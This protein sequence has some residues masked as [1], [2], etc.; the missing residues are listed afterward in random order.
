MPVYNYTTLDDP[1]HGYA[2]VSAST[3]RV[4]S[5]GVTDTPRQVHGFLL[6]GG[7]Y[8][9]L[10]DPLATNTKPGTEHQQPG[11]DRRGLRRRQRRPR[12]P[13]QR[14]PLTP[15]STIPRASRARRAGHQRRRSDRRNL[16]GQQRS[17]SRLPLERQH[18]HHHRRS[19]G[20]GSTIAARASTTMGQIVGLLRQSPAATTRF[21]LQRRHLHHHR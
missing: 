11:P 19:L 14:W 12:L 16:P 9:T 1:W 18:L 13:S 6:S 21:P 8:T 7:T 4:R 2:V 10:D 3:T 17:Q 5:S 15:P 20:L